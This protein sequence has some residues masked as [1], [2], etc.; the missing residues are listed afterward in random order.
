[1]IDVVTDGPRRWRPR[2][3]ERPDVVLIDM[4][5]RA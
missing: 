3:E 2:N 4:R 5:C 1:M